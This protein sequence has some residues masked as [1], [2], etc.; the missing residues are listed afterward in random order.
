[1]CHT[2]S[3]CSKIITK[4][5]KDQMQDLLITAPNPN[6]TR[7]NPQN[8]TDA[9]ENATP[10]PSH[11]VYASSKSAFPVRHSCTVTNLVYPALRYMGTVALHPLKVMTLQLGHKEK[12]ETSV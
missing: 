11:S 8:E 10:T 2:E 3:T 1:M 9:P 5:I 12:G 7:T 6:R 4:A